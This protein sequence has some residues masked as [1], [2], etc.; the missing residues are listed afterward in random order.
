MVG[1]CLSRLKNLYMVT[2]DKIVV[3]IVSN[4]RSIPGLY[5]EEGSIGPVRGPEGYSLEVRVGDLN[6]FSGAPMNDGD[7]SG[8]NGVKEYSIIFK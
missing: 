3:F 7:I 4:S 8:E 1:L 2:A 5:T 6:A